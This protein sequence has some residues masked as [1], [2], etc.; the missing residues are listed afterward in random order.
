MADG[1]PISS[2]DIVPQ[3]LASSLST[4]TLA[5]PMYQRAYSWEEENVSN[6]LTD[7]NTAFSNGESE[8][9]MG[10]IVL[11]GAEHSYAV[12]DGQQRLTTATVFIAATRDFL[13]AMANDA[14]ASSL[15][16]KF[17]L[18][19][20]TWT[21][22]I[23][24]RMSLS[25]YDNDFFLKCILG[26][27]NIKPERESHQRLFNARQKCLEF[28][29]YM[30]KTHNDWFDRL[31]KLVTYMEHKARIIQVIVPNEANAYVIF[32]TLNDRGKD[33]SASDLLKNY[34]F[35]R[36]GDRI[37]EVQTKWNQMLGILDSHGGDDVVITYIRQLWSA[38]REVAREKELFA[39]IK[40]KIVSSQQAVDFANELVVRADHYSAILNP[41]HQ[42]WKEIGGDAQSLIQS[43]SVLKLERYRPALLGLL[44][45]FNGKELLD[46]MRIILNGSVR[47]LIA[48]GAGGG[49]LEGAYSDVAR[50]VTAGEITTAKA[51][52]QELAKII[53]NDD[54]FRTAFLSLRVSK[55]FLARYFLGAL[56]RAARGEEN[57]ELIPN[58]D[59]MFVNLEH[60]LPENPGN[61]W[62]N[63]TPELAD[64]F[65]RRLGNLAL[66]S[67]KKNT[68]IGNESF[69]EKRKT[70]SAS[71]FVL[72]KSVGDCEKW[73]A[74]DI[75]ARQTK[76]ADL[77]LS[78]WAYKA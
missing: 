68:D 29:E 33:L 55:A 6:F 7:I 35:G 67:T 4:N 77:A 16:T 3:G 10:A 63:W 54:F 21:Q 28:L 19:K 62:P 23:S 59:T 22:Q 58:G 1:K 60:V 25:V 56:E 24:P 14:V 75:D 32:E 2:L 71:E 36:A 30:N 49:S 20:D 40:A 76:L 38:T 34:L 12:V 50:K 65:A 39:K 15:E 51:F 48:V 45:R 53:P 37:D 8:Y 72:T 46:S 78:V 27:E 18:T 13:K 44:G 66:L 43:L 69:D 5:V 9:F 47:Y 74:A 57:C 11:Q 64:T 52:G 17:L 70:F 73:E 41:S 31:A 42:L 61:N 26:G